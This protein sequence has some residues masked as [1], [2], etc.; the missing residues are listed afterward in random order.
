V[1]G[2]SHAISSLLLLLALDLDHGLLL[3]LRATAR[4]LRLA[5]LLVE[6]VREAALAAVLPVEV[7]GHEDTRAARR[8]HATQPRD[9]AVAVDLVVLQRGELDL[10]VLVLDLLRLGVDLLLAL[11]AAAA[12]TEHEVQRR[13]LLDVVV[14]ERAAI[15]KLLAREDQALLVGRDAL[16]VLDLGLHVVNRIGRLDLQRDGL[17]SKRLNEDLHGAEERELRSLAVE[18]PS[19]APVRGASR[20][21]ACILF[22]SL[23]LKFFVFLVLIFLL[24]ANSFQFF[25]FIHRLLF[26]NKLVTILFSLEG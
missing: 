3:L 13:L 12:Q 15:L 21:S 14:R 19:S 22:T 9:L 25:L 24:I 7:R 20:S 1:K 10:L 8:A 4:R 26:R 2:T 5:V 17:A 18:G 6:H 23:L 16:L 11:L